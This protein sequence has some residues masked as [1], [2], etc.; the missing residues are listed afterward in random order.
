MPSLSVRL[1]LLAIVIGLLTP[2]FLIA[3]G[4]PKPLPKFSVGPLPAGVATGD[5][6]GDNKLDLVFIN[7]DHFTITV[8]LGRGDG[9]F[10]SAGSAVGKDAG[11]KPVA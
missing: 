9:T 10:R 8:V 6:N 3:S 11:G 2:A 7:Q 4:F 5:F 1:C